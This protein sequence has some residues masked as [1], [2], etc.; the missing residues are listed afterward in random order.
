MVQVR[1]KALID[2][3]HSIGILF[4][5]NRHFSTGINILLAIV[6]EAEQENKREKVCVCCSGK[7]F[8]S[9]ESQNWNSDYKIVPTMMICVEGYEFCIKY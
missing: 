2:C 3:Y 9:S 8:N 7:P 1:R 5:L 4:R 6:L